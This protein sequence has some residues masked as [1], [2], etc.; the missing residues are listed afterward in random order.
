MEPLDLLKKVNPYHVIALMVDVLCGRVSQD[1]TYEKRL[2]ALI[3]KKRIQWDIF[4][5]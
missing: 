2:K 1:E 5:Y 3:K 4:I